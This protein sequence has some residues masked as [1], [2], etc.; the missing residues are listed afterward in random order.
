[1]DIVEIN[2]MILALE[3]GALKLEDVIKW[4]DLAIIHADVPDDRLFDVSVATCPNTAVAA[5]QV[6]GASD[7]PSLV[8]KKAFIYFLTGLKNHTTSYNMVAQKLYEMAFE[9]NITIPDKN[10]ESQMMSFWDALDIANEGVYGDPVVIKKE[11]LAFL[12]QYSH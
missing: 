10:A 11:M 1:M 2:A 6:F 7:T 8:A 9:P 12:K 4:A 5:L 3:C